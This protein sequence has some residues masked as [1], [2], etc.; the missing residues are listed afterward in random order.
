MLEPADLEKLLDD[1]ESDQVERKSNASDMTKIQQAVCAFAND[2]PG[3]GTPGY[4]FIGVA[5]NGK[6]T[7]I[8]VDERLLLKLSDMARSG[9]TVPLPNLTVAKMILKGKPVAVVEVRPADFPPVRFEG[10]VWIRIFSRRA[11]A[12]RQ[13]ERVLTERAQYGA[14]TFDRRPCRGSS[15]GDLLISSFGRITSHK[16]SRRKRSRR[17]TGRRRSSSRR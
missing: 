14:V 3:H 1:L 16:R 12:S 10:Q 5:D 17:T 15:L 7:G 9:K 6:P 2:L 13:E 11:I 4:V 8:D